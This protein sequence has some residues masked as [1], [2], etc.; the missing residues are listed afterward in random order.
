MRCVVDVEVDVH[1]TPT[2][3]C[4]ETFQSKRDSSSL[5]HE[6]G[7]ADAGKVHLGVAAKRFSICNHTF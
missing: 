2:Q 3:C 6:Q 4:D 5:L 1:S 7:T